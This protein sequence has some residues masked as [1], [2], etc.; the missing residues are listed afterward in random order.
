M[1]N[2]GCLKGFLM[3]WMRMCCM[4]GFFLILGLILK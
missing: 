2:W 4:V 1:K 3:F